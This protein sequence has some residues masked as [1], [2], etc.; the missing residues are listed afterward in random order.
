MENSFTSASLV[1]RKQAANVGTDAENRLSQRAFFFLLFKNV[2]DICRRLWPARLMLVARPNR[3]C[4]W[5][6]LVSNETTNE[7]QYLGERGIVEFFIAMPRA[8]CTGEMLST[9]SE[10]IAGV[11]EDCCDSYLLHVILTSKMYFFKHRSAFPV[12]KALS[13]ECASF[14]I[15]LSLWVDFPRLWWFRCGERGHVATSHYHYH[16]QWNFILAEAH[17]ARNPPSDHFYFVVDKNKFFQ[18]SL[19]WCRTHVPHLITIKGNEKKERR[20]KT[21]CSFCTSHIFQPFLYATNVCFCV[22]LLFFGVATITKKGH[23]F[24]VG[25]GVLASVAK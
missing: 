21:A 14:G 12:Q 25:V 5:K 13:C 3:K 8:R 11:E 1:C 9:I 19:Y 2:I 18:V 24:S 23:I 20:T 6:C 22:A 17:A 4:I 10:Y 7:C 16:R 15:R